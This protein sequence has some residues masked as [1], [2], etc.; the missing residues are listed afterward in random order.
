M[1]V[2]GREEWQ[3]VTAKQRSVDNND[4]ADNDTRSILSTIAR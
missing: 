4:L 3:Q 2:C 1:C